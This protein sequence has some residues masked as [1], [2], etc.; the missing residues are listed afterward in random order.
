MFK[1]K[2]SHTKNMRNQKPKK[3]KHKTTWEEN[4]KAKLIQELKCEYID[5]LNE[6]QQRGHKVYQ[7]EHEL[8]MK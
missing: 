4:F 8:E 7:R 5:R 6:F 1:R 2:N 3:Y